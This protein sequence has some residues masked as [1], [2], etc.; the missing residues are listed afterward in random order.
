MCININI[1]IYIYP[2]AT[3]FKQRKQT[4]PATFHLGFSENWCL[5]NTFYRSIAIVGHHSFLDKTISVLHWSAICHGWNHISH[6]SHTKCIENTSFNQLNMFWT[7]IFKIAQ[8]FFRCFPIFSHIF[9]RFL[10][11]SQYVSQYFHRD[12]T[13]RRLWGPK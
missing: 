3:Y 2:N 7:A 6:I 11:V 1:Y 13:P 10:G 9:P 4:Q 8:P 5:I 12:L